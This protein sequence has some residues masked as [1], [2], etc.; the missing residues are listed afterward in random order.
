MRNFFTISDGLLYKVA[1]WPVGVSSWQHRHSYEYS[2]QV[3]PE[4]SRLPSQACCALYFE[5]VPHVYFSLCPGLQLVAPP[6]WGESECCI[7]TVLHS[8]VYSDLS[9]K[10]EYWV[11]MHKWVWV[12]NGCR[13][14]GIC[15]PGLKMNVGRKWCSCACGKILVKHINTHEPAS[16]V[17]WTHQ[18]QSL[19][20]SYLSGFLL[21]KP[22]KE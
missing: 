5:E 8:C 9:V 16:L 6:T 18:L 14:S 11:G 7:S 3:P 22:Q 1:G 15:Q 4:G 2:L 17:K 20:L 10:A 13:C 21:D 12:N 19:S